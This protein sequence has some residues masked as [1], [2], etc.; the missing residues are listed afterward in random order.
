MKIHP[1]RRNLL[2]SSAV[3]GVA[4]GFPA[5]V[6]STV[7][8]ATAPSNQITIGGIGTGSM[9]MGNLKGF[10]NASGTRLLAVCDVDKKHRATAKKTIDNKYGNTDCAEYNDYRE[11]LARDDIDAVFHAL[12]DHWHGIICVAAANAGKDIYGQKPLA[13]TIKEGRAIVD[14]VERNGVIWQTGSQQRSDSRFRMACELAR[15]G[16]IGKVVRAE[17][18]LPGG[19]GGGSA[20]PVPVPEGLDYDMWLGPAPEQPCRDFKNGG[21]HW[22][23]RWVRDFSGGQITDWSGHNID[24]SHWGLGLD[25][26]GPVEVSGTGKFADHDFFNV[27]T[28][29]DFDLKYAGG[30]HI[31]VSNKHQTGVRFVGEEGWIQVTRT[32]IVAS[33]PSILKDPI[34]SNGIHLYESR[35]HHKNFLDCIRS[36][37]ETI[38][39]AEVGHR[40]ISAGLLGEI[41]IY[42]G[43]KL[44][45]NPE[46]EEFIG[47]PVADGL[48]SRSMREPWV[49]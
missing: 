33:H 9:G 13:R 18:G 21:P 8:G 4:A 17:A 23:W 24:I 34:P 45:W 12:P 25:R 27:I 32:K 22:N 38:C 29:F 39:P 37:K 2:K 41:A 6:P 10:L 43:R 31:N 46:I 19:Y 11:L 1:S 49:I 5:I 42:T 3:L 30:E 40:S 48:L 47:D 36:R 7:L 26:T 44:K 20:K 16:R 14:A 35:D 15:N 28:E